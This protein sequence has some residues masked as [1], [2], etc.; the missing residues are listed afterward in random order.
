[1][2]LYGYEFKQKSDLSHY[3]IL[4][5]KWGV[6]RYQ[7]AD[8]TMTAAGRKRYGKPL[9]D[10]ISQVDSRNAH[11][12]RAMLIGVNNAL[13]INK[14]VRNFEKTNAVGKDLRKTAVDKRLLSDSI[15]FQ[16]NE[17]LEKKYGDKFIR[18]SPEQQAKYYSDGIQM[19]KDRASKEDFQQLL[20]K[21]EE[22]S[23]EYEKQSRKF[24]EDLMGD[25]G[26][27]PLKSEWAVKYNYLTKEFSK[28]T[29]SDL[30]A[31][32]LLKRS[33]GKI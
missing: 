11:N 25:Y 9:A 26:N 4:G 28:Q 1:M 5:M 3:G 6:R 13:T 24:I 20:S 14:A 2:N 19:F 16:V 31:I 27:V 21:Y 23:K 12:T 22:F 32:E 29:I 8:G 33:G 30:A 17:E 18:L 7:N 15:N 10:N